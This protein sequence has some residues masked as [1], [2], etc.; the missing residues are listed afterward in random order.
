MPEN[1]LVIYTSDNGSYMFRRDDPKAQDHV[2]DETIQAY[3]ADRHTSNSVFRGTKHGQV[4]IQTRLKVYDHAGRPVGAP[5][6]GDNQERLV[7]NLTH[8]LL[9]DIIWRRASEAVLGS[10]SNPGAIRYRRSLVS[11]FQDP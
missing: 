11:S 4:G 6:E 10:S 2:D 7:Y 1:T 5:E 3:R 8:D 9:Y